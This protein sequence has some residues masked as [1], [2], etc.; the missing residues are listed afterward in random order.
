MK[1]LF[2]LTL[3]ALLLAVAPFASAQTPTPTP[4]PTVPPGPPPPAPF[5]ASAGIPDENGVVRLVAENDF[6][7]ALQPDFSL[8][9]YEIF[10]SQGR[11]LGSTPPGW[12]RD[13]GPTGLIDRIVAANGNI[14]ELSYLGERRYL[15]VL[16]APSGSVRVRQAFEPGFVPPETPPVAANPASFAP[17][18]MPSTVTTTSGIFDT[19]PAPRAAGTFDGT[20]YTVAPGD[21]LYRISIR[22]NT[23]ILTLAQRNNIANP[24]SIHAGQRLRITP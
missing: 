20:F 15:A 24:N 2:M 9:Y 22:F 5:E 14:V 23:G 19:G 17:T 21:N 16:I 11:F 10:D 13:N 7:V 6:I 3:V 1:P 8:D 4:T 18:P 12:R